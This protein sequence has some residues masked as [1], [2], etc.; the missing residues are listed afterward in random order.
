MYQFRGRKYNFSRGARR[1]TGLRQALLPQRDRAP[2]PLVSQISLHAA[3]NRRNKFYNGSATNWSSGVRALR[4]TDPRIINYVRPATTRRQSWPWSTSDIVDG[5]CW[6]HDR[7]AVATFL[8]R[9]ALLARYMLSSF[10]C[11]SVCPSLR[12]SNTSRYCIESTEWIEL[13]SSFHLSYTVLWGNSGISNIRIGLVPPGTDRHGGI[14]S[15]ALAQ[16][17]ATKTGLLTRFFF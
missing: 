1:G 14:A 15:S 9:D 2:A 16:S 3:H 6:Q 7:L 11:L 10:V 8:P 13:V 4:S 17:C 5:L 12:P